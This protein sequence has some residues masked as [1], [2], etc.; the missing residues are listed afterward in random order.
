MNGFNPSPE[1]IQMASDSLVRGMY[2]DIVVLVATLVLG[3]TF[4]G[5]ATD[6]NNRIALIPGI[7][8]TMLSMVLCFCA[9]DKFQ[10]SKQPRTYLEYKWINA[11]GSHK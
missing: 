7:A 9:Y 1:A 11:G 5:F 6:K 3:L 2:I 4:S 8:F 10:D